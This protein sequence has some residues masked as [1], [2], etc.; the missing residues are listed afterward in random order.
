MSNEP[1]VRER[2]IHTTVRRRQM[3]V[4]LATQRH[5]AMPV[6]GAAD[7]RQPSSQGRAVAYPSKIIRESYR[8]RSMMHK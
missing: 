5:L 7:R 3:T 8:C 2:T 4:V 6:R 1:L